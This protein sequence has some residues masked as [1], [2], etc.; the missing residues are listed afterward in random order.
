MG[1]NINLMSSQYPSPNDKSFDLIKK[2]CSNY[3]SVASVDFPAES[4][5]HGPAINDRRKNL[6]F[7]ICNLTAVL[8]DG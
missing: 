5:I 8:V 6:L 1:R 2:I 7:K 4:N 3:A